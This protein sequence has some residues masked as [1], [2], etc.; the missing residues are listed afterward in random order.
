MP[1]RKV[2]LA[3][4]VEDWD[5]Y[6]RHNYDSGYVRQLADA[7]A[8]GETLPPPVVARKGMR[9]VDGWH[10]V[11]A[12]RRHLGAGAEIDADVRSYSSEADIVRDAVR[13]N[14]KHGRKLDEQDKARSALLLERHGV[15]IEE[16]KVILSMPVEKIRTITASPGRIVVVPAGGAGSGPSA[17]GDGKGGRQQEKIPA[18]PSGRAPGA[19]SPRILT[20]DQAEA[21]ASSNGWSVGQNA[22][23]LIRQITTG[24]TAPEFDPAGVAA[25]WDLHDTIEKHLQRPAA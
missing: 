19:S 11:R 6:P 9:I 10:R 4:L 2:K 16:I 21:H 1:V 7:L 20:R 25:L 14:S 13:L 23:A 8:A 3:E 18:K 17:N 24:L 15:V 12:Y 5:I 22:R